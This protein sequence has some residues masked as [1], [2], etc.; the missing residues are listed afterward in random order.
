MAEGSAVTGDVKPWGPF[1]TFALGAVALLI[2]QLS[3]IAA[4]TAWYGLNLEQVAT[5]SQEGGALILFIFVSAPVQ[6]ALLVAA[7]ARKGDVVNYLG[8][9]VPRRSEV[10]FGIAGLAG[11]IVVGDTVSWLAGRNIVDRFQSDIYQAA[12]TAD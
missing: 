12:K 1:A 6:V 3:G 4:L 2:G 7:A 8:L 5:V 11:L 9:K 10:V